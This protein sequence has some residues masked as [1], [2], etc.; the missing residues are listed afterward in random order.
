MYWIEI[1]LL[2]ERSQLCIELI[3]RYVKSFCVGIINSRK[4]QMQKGLS[5]NR[6]MEKDE[7][8][9]EFV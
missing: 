1:G 5:W 8:C 3:R 6:E 7:H 2:L 4:L 9:G